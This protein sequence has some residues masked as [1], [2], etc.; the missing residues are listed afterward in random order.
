MPEGDRVPPGVRLE[1]RTRA[2]ERRRRAPHR[3]VRAAGHRT[4]RV[5]QSRE[6]GKRPREEDASDLR[7]R[8]AREAQRVSAPIL[9]DALHLATRLD[10]RRF[11]DPAKGG[12]R[13]RIPSLPRQQTPQG[14]RKWLTTLARH[15]GR[16]MRDALPLH[17]ELTVRRRLTKHH[18][19]SPEIDM[20]ERDEIVALLR[21][22]HMQ[23]AHECHDGHIQQWMAPGR[24]PLGPL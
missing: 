15:L 10:R 11:D 24:H 9:I 19:G 5:L 21:L 17:D 6:V 2:P 7:N 23:R 1:V 8:R 4:K 12:K 20:H 18:V 13:R 22:Q 14:G 16:N 3:D